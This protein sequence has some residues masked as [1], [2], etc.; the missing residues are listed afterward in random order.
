[1]VVITGSV[2]PTIPIAAGD[3]FV[4]SLDGI[5]STELSV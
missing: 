1:M 5:G 3:T 4:F 2:L